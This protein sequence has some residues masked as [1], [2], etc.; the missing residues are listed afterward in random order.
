MHV[1]KTFIMKIGEVIVSLRKESGLKQKQLAEDIGISATYLSQIEH[2]AE[3]PSVLVLSS[4]ANRFNLPLSAI[5]FKALISE[6][7]ENK[8]QKASVKAAEP[9]VNALVNYLLPKK[10]SI[11]GKDP[12]TRIKPRLKKTLV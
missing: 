8:E 3:N 4:I 12:L 6:N 9:I 5:I 11:K 2:N 10:D 7:F 1:E